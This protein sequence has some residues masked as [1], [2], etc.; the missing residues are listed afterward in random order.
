MA[1]GKG[2]YGGNGKDL[3]SLQESLLSLVF[4]LIRCAGIGGVF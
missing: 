1:R 3:V 2:G 4:L